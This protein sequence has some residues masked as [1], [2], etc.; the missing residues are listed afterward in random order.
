[1]ASALRLAAENPEK[2]LPIPQNGDEV[3][4]VLLAA[5]L[6]IESSRERIHDLD[7]KSTKLVKH[8]EEW[9]AAVKHREDILIAVS[10][11][12]ETFL[13]PN[14]NWESEMPQILARL[15]RAAGVS[16][17]YLFENSAESEEVLT[18]QRYEW[19]NKDI[20]PQIGNKNLKNLSLSRTGFTR[21]EK[22][23]SKGEIIAGK[24]ND[25]PAVEKLF[26]Q[27][28]GIKSVLVAPIRT[29]T[30]WWGFLG[31]DDCVHEHDWPEGV[32]KALHL[33]ASL[34]GSHLVNNQ[35]QNEMTNSRQ[36]LQEYIDT[37]FTLNAKIG[38]DNRFILINRIAV[39]ASGQ[40]QEE[41]MTTKFTESRLWAF[42]SAVHAR[43][44]DAFGRACKGEVI[45]Y[46][47]Q[48]F[49]ME[50]VKSINFSLT[51]V[52]KHDK[53][54]YIVAEARDIT[55][56]KQVETELMERSGELERINQAM[57][58]RELKMIELKEQIAAL[59]A[60]VQ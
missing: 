22:Q 48:I 21:W 45:V 53:V 52:I 17:A 54:A 35:T 4:Q 15:G 10:R 30:G 24:T 6:L 40:S 1:M 34:I 60:K 13:K 55:R 18:T 20:Q 38:V 8:V 39:V 58:G 11:I 33:A 42:D 51:P 7:A 26:L 59:K 5:Q 36:E 27:K 12:A 57:V 23:L 9:T 14:V 16:R 19:V 47:E 31:F 37:M 29:S 25:M 44:K 41:L 2:D 3:D 49:I 56:Q 46:D 32:A 28:Q 50:Q 43:I